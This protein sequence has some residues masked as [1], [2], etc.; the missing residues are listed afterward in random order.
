MKGK[1]IEE[2]NICATYVSNPPRLGSNKIVHAGRFSRAQKSVLLPG[3]VKSTDRVSVRC[4]P[5]SSYGSSAG[6]D[7]FILE[8]LRG[9]AGG[10]C[11]T[12][13]R[14]RTELC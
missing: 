1:N 8:R 2:Y 6:C 14:D 12:T 4:L 7:I 11:V 13:K 5:S 3:K 10:L 9:G